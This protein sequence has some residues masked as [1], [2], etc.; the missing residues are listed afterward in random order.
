M[1][2]FIP[3]AAQTPGRLNLFKFENFSILLDYA[4]NPA[5]MRALKQFS[6]NLEAT[7]KVCIIAGIGDR[8]D[9][10][11]NLIGSIAAEMADEIIIRQDKRL[12]GKTEEELIKMLEDGIQMK[13]PKMK[14]TVIP[15]EKEA[16][17]YAVNNAKKGSLII[18]CSDVVPD[19]L[20]L[21]Q[22]FKAQEATG[23]KV[24]AQ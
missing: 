17:T 24:F 18:L 7:H 21:V 12:R 19:A 22:K 2:T 14:T 20:A 5:G 1:E 10:D 6:D 23:E 11:N 9:E 3:S 16:I 13:D 15:S 8:R 4:H